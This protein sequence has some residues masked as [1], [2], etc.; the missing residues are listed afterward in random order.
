MVDPTSNAAPVAATLAPATATLVAKGLVGRTARLR[1]V[2]ET[3]PPV[4][5]LERL[6]RP[7]SLLIPGIL[8][9]CCRAIL[10]SRLAVLVFIAARTIADLTPPMLA[11]R[12]G[13][14]PPRRAARLARLPARILPRAAFLFARLCRLLAIVDYSEAFPE[15]VILFP[16]SFL[17]EAV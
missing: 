2:V 17:H 13:V 14:P 9:N 8:D 15:P 11:A 6:V 7:A 10:A 3:R 12:I 1:P 4:S 5:I 16:Y